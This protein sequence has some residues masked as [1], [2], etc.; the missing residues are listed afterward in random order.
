MV[1]STH[2]AV[3]ER[4]GVDG[5]LLVAR[6]RVGDVGGERVGTVQVD[7][8]QSLGTD[9]PERGGD[10]RTPVTTLRC[11]R[12]VA[13]TCHQLGPGRGD[14]GD[15][16]PR[17]CRFPG[18]SESGQGGNDDVE[19]ILDVSAE[20]DRVGERAD[21]LQELDDRPWPAVRQDERHRV[22][23]LGPDVDEMN[24]EP[25][26]RRH[27]L[28]ETIQFLLES[29]PVVVLLPVLDK[30]FGVLQANALRPVG[31]GL[32]VR[33]TG[34]CESQPQ[35]VDLGVGDRDGERADEGRGCGRRRGHDR[36]PGRWLTVQQHVAQ[37]CAMHTGEQRTSLHTDVQ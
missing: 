31:N 17:L 18:E 1:R 28:G 8:E 15:V 5:V 24:V 32:L 3:V 10:D 37:W 11:P 13:E 20:R 19:G 12:R 33:P 34:P 16:P 36:A 23:I 7:S 6:Q 25:V 4:K 14:A 27:E 30:G 2:V 26:D 35:V 21:H 9:D 22:R 29:T